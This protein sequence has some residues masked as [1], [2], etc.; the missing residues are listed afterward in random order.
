MHKALFEKPVLR[1]TPETMDELYEDIDKLVVA[2]ITP[3]GVG[4]EEYLGY[5]TYL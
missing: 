2:G 1:K 3:F 4:G 5:G